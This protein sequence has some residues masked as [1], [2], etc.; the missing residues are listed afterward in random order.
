VKR[1]LL[2]ALPL[3]AC[4]SP[5]TSQSIEP[6]FA[7]TFSGLYALQQ[8]DDG[9]T[10]VDARQLRTQ[11]SCLRTGPEANG[12][13]EDWVCSVQ[14]LDA[15]TGFTQS[16]EVQVKPDGCWRA[17]AP[18]TAQ[19]ALHTDPSTGA[20]RANPLAAFDGCVDTSWH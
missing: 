12:P 3:A 2:L 1:L 20:K 17:D 16:F 15:G 14:Y 5:L 6:S 8:A 9:R 18:P 10:D 13:G 4:A 11:A 7:R 19:P